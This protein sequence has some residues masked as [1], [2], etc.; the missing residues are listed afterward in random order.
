MKGTVEDVDQF[1]C[2]II[3]INGN[4]I[5]RAFAIIDQNRG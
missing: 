3:L 2:I 4:K 1:S 5:G